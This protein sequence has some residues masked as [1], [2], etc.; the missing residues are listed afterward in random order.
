VPPWKRATMSN[1]DDDRYAREV[2]RAVGDLTKRLEEHTSTRDAAFKQLQET[3]EGIVVALRTD[4]HKA[5]IS[6]QLNNSDHSKTHDADRVERAARQV[7]VDGT[8][9]EIRNWSIW[10]LVGI[11][12]LGAFIIGWLVF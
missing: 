2:I 8:M 7:Q 12:A 1:L 6:L 11:V 5:I 4:V 10:A 3:V 9:K